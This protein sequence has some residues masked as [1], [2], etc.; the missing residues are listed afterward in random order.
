MPKR[1]IRYEDISSWESVEPFVPDSVHN[2]WC[3]LSDIRLAADGVKY[4]LTSSYAKRWLSI[5]KKIQ[6]KAPQFYDVVN[7][8]FWLDHN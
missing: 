2:L 5:C 8:Y 6:K 1:A 3:K 7:S 4:V